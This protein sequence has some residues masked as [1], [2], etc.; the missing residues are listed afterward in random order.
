MDKRTFKKVTNLIFRSQ[1]FD[2]YETTI[3]KDYRL[4]Y[5]KIISYKSYYS[6]EYYFDSYI[7]FKTN[8]VD[9]KENLN[10]D[11]MIMGSRIASDDEKTFSFNYKDLD[12]KQYIELLSPIVK[13]LDEKIIS[14]P[15]QYLNS[16]NYRYFNKEGQNQLSL[17]L[18]EK[19]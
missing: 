8:K 4:F 17:I 14:S 10:R 12:E 15:L 2:V 7:V 18:K 1:G 3:Y 11:C 9:L 6:D 19:L 5:M 16:I 13:T